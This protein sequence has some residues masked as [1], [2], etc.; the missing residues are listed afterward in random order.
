[1]T[2]DDG[3]SDEGGNGGAMGFG[4]NGGGG[5]VYRPPKKAPAKGQATKP[6]TATGEVAAA[7]VLLVVYRARVAGDWGH[8]A[9]TARAVLPQDAGTACGYGSTIPGGRN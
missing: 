6:S 3:G 1:M 7:A 5:S 2:S 8:R 4:G 9:A